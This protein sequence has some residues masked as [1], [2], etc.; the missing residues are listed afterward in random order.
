M[1]T[2]HTHTHRQCVVSVSKCIL[3]FRPSI[4]APANNPYRRV[5]VC[6]AGKREESR[7]EIQTGQGML[8]PY[9]VSHWF[10]STLRA[11]PK[12]QIFRSHVE[13]RSKFDGF[14]SRCSTFAE[15]TYLSPL[16][17]WYKKYWTWSSVSVY[18]RGDGR[19]HMPTR[20][21]MPTYTKTKIHTEQ[22]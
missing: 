11:R 10:S 15:C 3:L 19:V 9:S 21:H 22:R 20:A 6:H 1:A 2:T 12:S 17:I 13:L 18:G 5:S 7:H 16:R 14:R 8:V 4:S